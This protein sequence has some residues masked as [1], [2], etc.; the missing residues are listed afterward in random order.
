MGWRTIGCEPIVTLF[1]ISICNESVCVAFRVFAHFFC[2]CLLI[3]RSH[4]VR[5]FYVRNRH[6]IY[7]AWFG[8]MFF[9][10][11]SLWYIHV[12]DALSEGH[13]KALSLTP[14]GL[15]FSHLWNLTLAMAL[16]AADSW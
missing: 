16:F 13:S 3:I 7:C 2:F 6:Q 10:S 4:F 14:T 8:L 11:R 15:P 12:L 9:V 1:C 5:V